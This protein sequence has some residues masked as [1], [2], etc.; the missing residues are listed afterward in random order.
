M[1]T[2]ERRSV[3]RNPLLSFQPPRWAKQLPA[4]IQSRREVEDSTV[5]VLSVANKGKVSRMPQYFQCHKRA[6]LCP[7]LSNPAQHNGSSKYSNEKTFDQ[8]KFS[9]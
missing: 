5:W 9:F 1:G 6:I 2:E 7:A 8:A 4:L 3:A